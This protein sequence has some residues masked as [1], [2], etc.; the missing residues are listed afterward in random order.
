[1]SLPKCQTNNPDETRKIPK[2]IFWLR[3]IFFK[4]NPI[5]TNNPAVLNESHIVIKSPLIPNQAPN[6]AASLAS[7]P[8]KTGFLNKIFP[9]TLKE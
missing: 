7:P 5:I 1:M 9:I 3:L 8:P 2:G 4:I 6:R